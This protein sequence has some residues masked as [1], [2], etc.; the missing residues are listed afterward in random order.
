MAFGLLDTQFIDFAETMT[1]SRLKAIKNRLGISMV[2]FVNRVEGAMSAL[3]TKDSVT[4]EFTFDT[5]DDSFKYR[6]PSDKIWQHGAEYTVARPQRGMGR[7][8][9]MIPLYHYEIALGVT[10]RYLQE[11][12]AEQFTDEVRATVQAVARGRQADVWSRF[13]SSDVW[14]LD[15]DGVGTSPGFAGSGT[16]ADA[17]FGTTLRGQMTDASYTHYFYSEP[18]AANVQAALD[19]MIENMGLWYNGTLDIIAT[20]EM[21][22]VIAQWREDDIFVPTGSMLIRPAERETQTL[23]SADKYA[24]VYKGKVRVRHA[25]EGVEGMNLA[26]INPTVKPL[27]WRYDPIYGREAYLKDRGIY[28]LTQADILQVYGLGVGD[29]TAASFLYAE[30]G[31]TEYVAPTIVR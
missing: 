16:G 25:I 9:H 12:N 3:S 15:D 7:R 5:T 26:V 6:G 1:E 29:R 8:G 21:L 14:A 2:E 31:A 24:G 11:A 17:F 13:W 19:A 10:D 23:V 30:T 4:R 20:E 22:D 18:D 27:A 28:P